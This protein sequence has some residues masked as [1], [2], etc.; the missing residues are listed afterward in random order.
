MLNCSITI[1]LFLWHSRLQ[2]N[3]EKIL[4]RGNHHLGL[5]CTHSKE[6]QVVLR[7]DVAHYR[8]SLLSKVGNFG[9]NLTRVRLVLFAAGGHCSSE[10]FAVVVDNQKAHNSFVVFYSQDAFFDFRHNYSSNIYN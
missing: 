9:C 1:L 3:E 7:V 10:N 4:V 5:L 8:S 6:S 2:D